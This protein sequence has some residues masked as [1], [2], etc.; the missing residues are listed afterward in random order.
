M[1]GTVLCGVTD[2]AE[3]HAAAQLAGALSERLGL[4][5]V[6]AHVVDGVRV[7]V[8]ESLTALQGRKGGERALRAIARGLGLDTRVELRLA[9]GDRAERLAQFAAEEDA[10][11][12]V[13]GSKSQGFRGRK[14]RYG[15]ARELEAATPVPVVIAPPQAPQRSERRLADA[16]SAGYETTS[17]RQRVA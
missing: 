9:H 2:S 3:G 5:L 15:L 12:V 14:L 13:L 16:G 17:P 8:E 7:D 4:R 10:D 1:A 11:L 6:L